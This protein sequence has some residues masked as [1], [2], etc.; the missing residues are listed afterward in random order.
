MAVGGKLWLRTDG[1]RHEQWWTKEVSG[2]W[3]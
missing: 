2:R 3:S 1:K